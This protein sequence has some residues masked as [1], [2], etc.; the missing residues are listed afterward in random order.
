MRSG[1]S[2]RSCPECNGDGYRTC[3]RC[4]GS[5]KVACQHCGG[6]GSDPCSKCSGGTV[7]CSSCSG[8][9]TKACTRCSNGTVPCGT[10]DGESTVPCGCGNG[11]IDCDTCETDG[12]LVTAKT[13]K[14]RYSVRESSSTHS[15]LVSDHALLTRDIASRTK[16]DEDVDVGSPVK[17]G[18]WVQADV[19][20]RHHIPVRYVKYGYNGRTFE[21]YDING[22]LD[23]PSAP[24]SERLQDVR[25]VMHEQRADLREEYDARVSYLEKVLTER[26]EE[27]IDAYNRRERMILF[28]KVT[29]VAL[30]AVAAVGLYLLI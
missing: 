1:D 22:E 18:S 4:N 21:V 28:G 6:V 3:H 30:L 9:G 2:E 10:C 15:E 20:K 13:S 14:I 26:R 12:E 7:P 24:E 17:D 16:T 5:S 25:D 19:R 29:K 23:T 8:S 11:R 27:L